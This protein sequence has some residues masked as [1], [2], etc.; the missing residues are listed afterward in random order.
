MDTIECSVWNNGTETWG[1]K[2]LGG[3]KV[4]QRYF[5]R[6]ESPVDV[7]LDGTVYPFN[8]DKKSF[9][10][11]KCGELLGVPLRNW[12]MRNGLKSGDRVWLEILQPYRCFKAVADPDLHRSNAK[13]SE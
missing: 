12:I 1:L 10:T 11:P 9:W 2:I 3:L 13:L 7:E 5:Q 4:R 6:S 8:I